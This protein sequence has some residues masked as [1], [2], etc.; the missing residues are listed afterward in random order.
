MDLRKPSFIAAAALASAALLAVAPVH[1]Q[2]KTLLILKGPNEAARLDPHRDMTVPVAE[3]TT[4]MTDSLVSIDADLKTVKPHLAQSWTISPDGKTLVFKL[5]QDV[6]Y[7]SGRPMTAKDVV[8]TFERWRAPAT[9]SP[10]RFR[11]ASLDTIRAVDDHTVEM[12]LARPDNEF[13]LQIGTHYGGIID[14][15]QAAELKDNFGVTG[16]NGVGPFCFEKWTPRQEMVLKRHDAYRWG[17]PQFDNKGPAKVERIVFRYVPEESTLIATLLSGGG[18]LTSTMPDWAKEKVLAN[19]AIGHTVGRAVGF[20]PTLHLR[21]TKPPLNDV[22][23]RR[24]LA[25]AINRPQLAT[26]VWGKG[27]LPAWGLAA[28]TVRDADPKLDR[29]AFQYDKAGA[30]K[31][32]DQAGWKM[33]PGGVRMRNGEKLTLVVYGQD[34]PQWRNAMGAIHGMWRDVGVDVQLRL[35]DPQVA[36]AKLASPEWNVTIYNNIHVSAGDA[37]AN[38]FHSRNIGSSNRT[39]WKDAETDRLLDAARETQSE[40]ERARLYRELQERLLAAQPVIPLYNDQRQTFYNKSMVKGIKA[41]GTYGV[42]LYKALDIEV[43]R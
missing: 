36:F 4:L 13:L 8:G 26:A 16:F 34:L 6:K 39:G 9:R 21:V 17:P 29:L 33:G 19:P 41:F 27:S 12:K 7:C 18:M 15:E 28:P 43:I 24:A 35:W 37:L 31:M 42:M 2:G 25:M 3:Y 14:P 30:G 5:R 20:S 1:A 10:S 11:I 32:L 40:T 38:E 23:V 22:L